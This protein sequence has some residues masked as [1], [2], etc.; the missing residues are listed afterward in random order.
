KPVGRCRFVVCHCSLPF[1]E[2][3]NPTIRSPNGSLESEPTRQ[4]ECFL[5][6]RQVSSRLCLPPVAFQG[7]RA[8]RLSAQ[9][10]WPAALISLNLSC[11]H[12]VGKKVLALPQLAT[13]KTA[14]A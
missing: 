4:C 5:P 11:F 7:R 10:R 9:H 12:S 1:P 6:P 13:V 3:Q 2:R 14:I 8:A